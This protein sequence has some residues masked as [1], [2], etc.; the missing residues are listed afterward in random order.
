MTGKL[1]DK[2]ATRRQKIPERKAGNDSGD[3][4]QPHPLTI[5]AIKQFARVYKSEPK[6]PRTLD[7]YI[8]N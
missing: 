3:N 7:G 1:M 8:V 6:L 2:D 4:R 5:E